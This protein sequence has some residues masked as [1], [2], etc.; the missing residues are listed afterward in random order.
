MTS[1]GE[2]ATYLP[3]PG[4]FSTYATRF[5][6][7]SL[8]FALGW[9][10]WF[11][12]VI[13]VAADVTILCTSHSILTPMAGI[14]A[15]VWS[16]IFLVII[17]SLNSLSV[18]VYG[19]S[20]YW[21]ALIKVVTVIIFIIIGLLTILGIMGGE[22]VGFETFTKGDGP[23]LGGNLGGSL[24]SI[25]GV[26]LVAGFSFQGTELIGITAGES[27]NPERAVPKA[28]KQ[29]FWR[30]LLFYILAIFVIG[31]LIPY[32]S[33]ALMGGDDNIATSIYTRV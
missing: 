31:M 14:P 6:D 29:V 17:F 28:I 19:E 9:N 2:M 15:W 10:Y 25:L 3:V 18:R 11:N 21:F 16:C 33:N 8:G 5:V 7:P 23:I 30:I 26:F 22:F 4:S 13:T 1:L 27:E 32:D 24:L 12:W 20:E